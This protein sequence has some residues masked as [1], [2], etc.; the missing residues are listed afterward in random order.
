MLFMQYV[1]E[2][3]DYSLSVNTSEYNNYFGSHHVINCP[4]WGVIG[5]IRTYKSGKKVWIKPYRKGKE[6]KNTA[7]YSSKDYDL[8]TN[9]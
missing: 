6:R 4:S 8:V 9:I 3:I 1:K 5:H 2:N 7:V